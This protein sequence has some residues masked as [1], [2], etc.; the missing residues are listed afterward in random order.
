M[1]K[2]ERGTAD[3]GRSADV[4]LDE[5]AVAVA[6]RVWVRGF[7]QP[8]LFNPDCWPGKRP[9]IRVK[10]TVEGENGGSKKRGMV[11][12]PE[13]RDAVLLERLQYP[14]GMRAGPG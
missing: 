13:D 4:L 3:Q 11:T 5:H 6:P 8:K 10:V 1:S 2:P 12:L 9:A 14:Y 7:G